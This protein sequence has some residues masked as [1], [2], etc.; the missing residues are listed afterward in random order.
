[1]NFYYVGEN[2]TT[3]LVTGT[4][5]EIYKK[6]F[7]LAKKEASNLGVLGVI[8]KEKLRT[9]LLFHCY[10][11]TVYTKLTQFIRKYAAIN[12]LEKICK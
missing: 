7:E 3:L 10:D 2:N 11:K 5:K 9:T 8:T 12:A 4:N 6:V 1:L